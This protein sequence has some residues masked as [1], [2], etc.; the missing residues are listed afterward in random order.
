MKAQAVHEL[1][2]PSGEELKERADRQVKSAAKTRVQF[3][4]SPRALARLK[5]LQEK[6]EAASYAEVVKNA[7]KLYDG[8]IEEVERGSEFMIKDK[9]GNIVPFR[10]FL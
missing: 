10:M 8:L 9:D 1:L 7:L 2:T 5:L 6:T 4:F 3:D